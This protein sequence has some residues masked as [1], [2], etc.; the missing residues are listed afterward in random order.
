MRCLGLALVQNGHGALLSK[1]LL[2]CSFA[3]LLLIAACNRK[4]EHVGF[5][6]AI[7]IGPYRMSV[8]SVEA[9]HR[10]DTRLLVVFVHWSGVSSSS[11]EEDRIDFVGACLARRFTIVD[12]KGNEFRSKN[13]MPEEQYRIQQTANLLAPGG[14]RPSQNQYAI[15]SAQRER[16]GWLEDPPANWAVVFEIPQE[17]QGF[18]LWVG[19]SRLGLLSPF[20]STPPDAAI[21]LN[22]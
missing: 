8:S 2:A 3:S 5:G 6:Q 4:P 11:P 10:K 22:Y 21:R 20:M 9:S 14:K 15:M 18:T 1:L 7:S 17:A 13:P 19:R 16:T 12:G